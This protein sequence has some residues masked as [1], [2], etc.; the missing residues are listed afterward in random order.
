MIEMIL[1][2]ADLRGA[3]A[4]VDRNRDETLRQLRRAE[5]S[6][7]QLLLLP[8][9]SLTGASCGDLFFQDLLLES[10]G[11]AAFQLAAMSR[12]TVLVFGLPIRIDGKT[13]AASAVCW[14]GQ[15]RGLVTMTAL[16]LEQRRRFSPWEGA[17]RSVCLYG[18]TVPVGAD[19][20]FDLPDS[21]V[22]LGVLQCKADEALREATPLLKQGANLLA[23]QAFEPT[24]ADEYYKKREQLRRLSARCACLYQNAGRTETST[25]AVCG[26]EA[27]ILS[28]CE[29]LSERAAFAPQSHIEAVLPTEQGGKPGLAFQPRQE[30]LISDMPYAPPEGPLRE[31][32]CRDAME[33][34]AQGLATRMARIEAKTAVLG[35]S[36]GLDSAL[37]LLISARAL[38]INRLPRENLLAYSLPCFGTTGRTRSNSLK[39]MAALGLSAR[40]IDISRSVRAHLEDIGHDG[41]YDA[42][43]ENAQARERTQVLM[44][45]ANMRDGLMV[46]TGDMSEL[47]LGF[48]TFGGDHL[49]MYAV[50]GGLYKSAIRLILAQVAEQAAP[51]LQ[52]V[53]FDILDTPISPELKPLEDGQHTEKIVGPYALSDF[54]LY[55]VLNQGLDPQALL[56]Y[57]QTAFAGRF[58]RLE[59]LKWMRV[60]FQRYLAAQ[61]KR[62]CMSDGPQVLAHSLSPRGG[63]SLPSD[64]QASLWLKDIDRMIKQEESA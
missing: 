36:G 55:H 32:W 33:I 12:K 1:A 13:Y 21:S 18:Q 11:R 53:L 63:L 6:G 64:A 5:K 24:L 3:P 29:V 8:P 37:A 17:E 49:S 28:S 20:V 41:R 23:I 47:A 51:A 35:L 16:S 22:R 52:E 62:S 54:Y 34:P 39:L 48:T 56:R 57:A 60:F 19:L 30:I 25:D 26:G 59:L 42:A 45:I 9:L 40:E 27:F 4:D 31:T 50:N 46:G 10:A 38:E 7:A 43:Y 14:G 44:D 2:C 61:F 15:L 58:T